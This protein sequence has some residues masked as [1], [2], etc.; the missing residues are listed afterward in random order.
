M[1][2]PQHV[3]GRSKPSLQS[4]SAMERSPETRA[5]RRSSS[6]RRGRRRA[7][8]TAATRPGWSA[9]AVRRSRRSSRPPA[10]ASTRS[11]ASTAPRWECLSADDCRRRRAAGHL[12]PRR[13]AR[14]PAGPAGLGLPLRHR[15]ERLRRGP[16]RAFGSASCSQRR[17]SR[18]RVQ[19][20]RF[21]ADEAPYAT[22]LTLPQAY[23]ADAL[24]ALEMDGS[25]SRS[26]TAFPMCVVMPRMYG[27]KNVKWVS[28]DRG[29]A[30]PGPRSGT[31]SSAGTTRTR[32]SGASN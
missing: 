13:S 17:A 29:R 16:G 15:V 22:T 8:S 23:A 30:A 26:R 27:Y 9:R 28:S 11:A 10:G 4:R 25:R 2:Q 24:L 31:G 21:V 32:G 7:L 18:P 20:L 19:A 5:G 14:A 12:L 6:R 3:K 1:S